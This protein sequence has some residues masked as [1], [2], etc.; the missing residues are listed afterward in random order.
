MRVSG[1]IEAL[2][3][4]LAGQEDIIQVWTYQDDI[5]LSMPEN[6]SEFRELLQKKGRQEI[7]KRKFFLLSSGSTNQFATDRGADDSRMQVD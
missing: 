6:S 5:A 7:D 2:K 3:K 1:D 4:L